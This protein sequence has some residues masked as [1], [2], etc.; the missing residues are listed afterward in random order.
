[1]SRIL[2]AEDNP[3]IR[4]L[5]SR[6]LSIEGHD[7]STVDDGREAIA[8]ITANAF[9]AILLDFMMPNA[10]GFDVVAWIQEH[11]PDVAKSC[12]IILTAAVHELKNFDTSSVFATIT[13]PFDVDTLRET[14]RRCI[15]SH[16]HPV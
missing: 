9:D 6:V 14:V 5:V 16:P 8:E 4:L 3:E 10:S 1:M 11:R 15:D 2:I 12:V 13:K 7:V